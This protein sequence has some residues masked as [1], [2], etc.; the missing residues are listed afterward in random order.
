MELSQ[1]LICRGAFGFSHKV[2]LNENAFAAK[3]FENKKSFWL[4]LSRQTSN[5]FSRA[6]CLRFPYWVELVIAARCNDSPH[7]FKGKNFE[8]V[9]NFHRIQN[10]RQIS[11][12]FSQIWLKKRHTSLFSGIWREI[13]KKFIKN[14][15]KKCKI[16]SVCDW[17]NEYSLIQ[18]RKSFGDF[19]RI[20]FRI[21]RQIPEKSDAFCFFNQICENELESCRKFWNLW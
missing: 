21:S 5:R 10:F 13:R 12:L 11:D 20:F 4:G 2:S 19:W 9:N 1:S 7:V 18:S 15:Q 17:I 14:S 8:I 16:R 6:K 3:G